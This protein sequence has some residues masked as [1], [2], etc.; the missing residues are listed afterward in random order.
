MAAGSASVG[1]AMAV[2]DVVVSALVGAVMAEAAAARP[3]KP[4]PTA[5]GNKGALVSSLSS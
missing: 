2:N 4:E 1:A 5:N 3:G